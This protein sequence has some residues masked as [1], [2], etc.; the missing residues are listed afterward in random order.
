MS[1]DE[2]TF[3]NLYYSHD[4][5][6]AIKRRAEW[7]GHVT[8]KRNPTYS[9]ETNPSEK[10]VL[11]QNF[12]ALYELERS[13][14]AFTTARQQAK[15]ESVVFDPRLTFCFLK[16]HSQHYAPIYDTTLSLSH[17]CSWRNQVS[18]LDIC[19]RKNRIRREVSLD[20]GQPNV[21]GMQYRCLLFFN[22]NGSVKLEEFWR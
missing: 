15:T 13:F 5:T 1:N 11:P 19:R 14:S 18:W 16:T 22:Q 2:K 8:I 17:A 3:H 20:V 10:L 7:D 9:T 21:A 12:L 6:E 4:T